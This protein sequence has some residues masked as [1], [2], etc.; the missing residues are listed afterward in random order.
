MKINVRWVLIIAGLIIFHLGSYASAQAAI[1]IKTGS[2]KTALEAYVIKDAVGFLTRMFSDSVDTSGAGSTFE[3]VIGTPANNALI[4]QQI[5]GGGI[6]LPSGKYASHGYAIKTIGNTIYLAAASDTGISPGIYDLLQQ[7]GAYF[8]ISG[9][10]LPALTAFAIKTI[11][12]SVAP[13]FKYYGLFPWDN[14]LC[15]MSGWNEEDFKLFI[16]RMARLRLNFIE[17]HFYPGMAYYNETYSNGSANSTSDHVADWANSF[18]PNQIIGGGAFGSLATFG[19][20][21]WWQNQSK[22]AAAQQDSCQ[23]MLRRVIDYAHTRGLSTV[24]GFCLMQPRGGNFTMTSTRGWSAMPDPLNANNVNLEVDRYRRLVQIYPNSDYYWMWQAEAGGALWNTITNDASASAL[25]T[26]YSSWNP[27][28]N[29]GGDIDYGYLFAQTVNK[30]TAAERSKIATGGWDMSEMFKGFD[31]YCPSEII[32]HNMNSWDT[33][34]GISE[35]TNEY[36]LGTARRTWMTDWWEY[37]GLVWFPEYRVKKQETMYKACVTNNVECVTLDGWKQSG[38]EHNIKYLAEFVWNPT[39]SGTQFYAD[40]CSKVY[41]APA[42]AASTLAN[43]YGVNDSLEPTICAATTGDYRDMN[44]SEGWQTLQLSAFTTDATTQSNCL[45]LITKQ[46]ALIAR[47]QTYSSTLKALRPQLSASGQYWLDLMT[48][49]LDFEV[50][51]VQS[52]IDIN[53]SYGTYKSSGAAAACGDLNTA[54]DQMFQSIMKLSECPRNTSDLGLIG[55]INILDYNVLKQFIKTNGGTVGA[56]PRAFAPD[57]LRAAGPQLREISIYG[58]NGRCVSRQTT[59][60]QNAKIP[61]LPSGVYFVRIKDAEGHSL[62][63]TTFV[64]E[65]KSPV[66]K[67]RQ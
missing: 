67:F 66:L 9:E 57:G 26:Q 44:I 28:G 32:F 23:A 48:N 43:F 12:V 5:T 63:V 15:G 22:G 64:S 11:N 55:Q 34:E 14:F 61:L 41:G 25:R 6:V 37:D 13:A 21:Q 19:T 59:M 35:A 49:R 60:A 8:Q 53:K 20:R 7:Y 52:L 54:L 47:V 10:I 29:K 42:S 30:L 38:V 56:V 3:I 18:Q 17:F 31:S 39:L 46:Q 50:L 45:T 24:V 2:P 36:K 33:R 16:D 58:V 4:S 40:Y 62:G 27:G 1:R 65:Q 51:Y